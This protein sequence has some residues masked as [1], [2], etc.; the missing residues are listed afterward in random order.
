MNE[1]EN[2]PR[3]NWLLGLVGGV[4]GG[5]AGYGL[6]FPLYFKYGLYGIVLPGAGIGLGCELLSRGKSNALGAVCG[7]SAAAL[8]LFTQWQ[9]TLPADMSLG[10]FLTHLH[11]LP[12]MTLVLLGAGVLFAF[13]FGRGRERVP[14]RREPK[15]ADRPEAGSN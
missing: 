1:S 6:F 15:A 12:T 10:F 14:R 7:I 3:A 2:A 13:W 8:G 9:I 5:A 11:Q 4:V